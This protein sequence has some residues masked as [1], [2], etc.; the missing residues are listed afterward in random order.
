MLACKRGHKDVVESL[1]ANGAEIFIRDNRHRT[2]LET[3]VRRN[4]VDLI[5]LLDTAVQIRLMQFRQHA[6]RQIIIADLRKAYNKQSLRISDSVVSSMEAMA[7]WETNLPASN[8]VY[9]SVPDCDA[10]KR[11][12]GVKPWQWPATVIK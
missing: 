4:H 10:G 3:V 8:V 1:V 12:Q 6:K 2:A 5:P 7:S 11:I 9:S